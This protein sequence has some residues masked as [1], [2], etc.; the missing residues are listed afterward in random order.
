M[1]EQVG[2]LRIVEIPRNLRRP[3][4]SERKAMGAFLERERERVEDV[5]VSV[6]MKLVACGVCIA[7]CV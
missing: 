1:L 7:A 2:V 3:M 6:S 4:Q 5:E